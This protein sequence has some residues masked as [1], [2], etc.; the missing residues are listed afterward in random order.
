[1]RSFLAAIPEKLDTIQR[2]A[3]IH[4]ASIRLHAC[5]DGVMAAVFSV[6]ESIVEKITRTFKGSSFS[7]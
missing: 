5:V 7:T 2:L 6:L 3:S 1:M 4:H